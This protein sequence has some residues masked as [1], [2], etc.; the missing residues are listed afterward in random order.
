MHIYLCFLIRAYP[1]FLF[2]FLISNFK[3]LELSKH[4]NSSGFLRRS[5]LGLS[6]SAPPTAIITSTVVG[7]SSSAVVDSSGAISNTKC[8]DPFIKITAPES[9]G[10][11]VDLEILGKTNSSSIHKNKNEKYITE[12]SHKIEARIKRR[13]ENINRRFDRLISAT[14]D[15]INDPKYEGTKTTSAEVEKSVTDEDQFNEMSSQLLTAEDEETACHSFEN[16]LADNFTEDQSEEWISNES[17]VGD[18]TQQ[19]PKLA[20]G[21][22][23]TKSTTSP[24]ALPCK[25]DRGDLQITV[26]VLIYVASISLC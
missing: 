20:D 3:Y 15:G 26:G 22:I 19:Q 16:V 11:A 12:Q 4:T 1:H 23:E 25:P 9:A 14:S 2:V 18:A 13:E 24:T 17:L 8:I 10:P 6:L 5:K 7:E 21:S